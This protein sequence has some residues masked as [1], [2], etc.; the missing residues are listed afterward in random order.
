MAKTKKKTSKKKSGEIP[1]TK[2]LLDLTEQKLT[3]QITS[4]RLEMKAGFTR[5]DSRFTSIESKFTSIESKFT[6]MDAKFAS[7][8]A[9]LSGMMALLEEQNSRNRYV[10]DGY[11]SLNDKQESTEARVEELEKKVFGKEQN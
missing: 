2:N 4:L 1:V 3:S 5:I 11:T 7:L 10:L 8:D 9:K 6:G